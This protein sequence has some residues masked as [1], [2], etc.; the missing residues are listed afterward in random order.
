[1]K[2]IATGLA[3]EC[4]KDPFYED[5]LH[6]DMFGSVLNLEDIRGSECGVCTEE[7]P[8][9]G[10]SGAEWQEIPKHIEART[11]QDAEKFVKPTHKPEDS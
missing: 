9:D 2:T 8:E 6:V 3:E 10:K 11:R 4:R 5:W 1:M 7:E